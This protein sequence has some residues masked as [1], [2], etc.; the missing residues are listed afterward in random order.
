M[1]NIFGKRIKGFKF[2]SDEYPKIG[3][4]EDMEDHIGEEGIIGKYNSALN[5]YEIVFKTGSWSYPAELVEGML[6]EKTRD[7]RKDFNHLRE[8]VLSWASNKGILEN[9]TPIAQSSK[10]MEEVVELNTA[11]VK[12]DMAGMK[13]GIGDSLVCLIIQARMQE[14]SLEEC[15][16]LALEE[17]E[18][19]TGE[20]VG[21]VF[22]KD[23]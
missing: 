23:I 5:S 21:G 2:S 11:I 13:D 19:R 14:V 22:V 1:K 4:L 7:G 16:L 3:W 10:T 18:G 20:M 9:G 6:E 15:L 12:G 17:I 8:R